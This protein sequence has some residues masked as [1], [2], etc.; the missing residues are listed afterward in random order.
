MAG[1]DGRAGVAVDLFTGA[2]GF[3]KGLGHPALV[4]A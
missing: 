4:V 3:V 2:G 1:P